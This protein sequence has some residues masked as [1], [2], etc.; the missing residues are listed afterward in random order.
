VEFGSDD[1]T[2]ELPKQMALAA[3]ATRTMYLKY[4]FLSPQCSTFNY[5]PPKQIL[6]PPE[7]IEEKV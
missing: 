6:P 3:I 5:K 4:D 2:M 7:I 1:F